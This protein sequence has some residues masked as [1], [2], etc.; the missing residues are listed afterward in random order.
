MRAYEFEKPLTIQ[1]T[2]D[3]ALKQ[4]AARIRIKQ[5]QLR[6]QKQRKQANNTASQITN[7]QYKSP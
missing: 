5:K 7:L 1:Q 6:L 2:Q 3:K 4:Q